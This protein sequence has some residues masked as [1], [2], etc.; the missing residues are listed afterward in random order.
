M[1]RNA[2]FRSFHRSF[3]AL[4]AAARVANAV[5]ARRYPRGEDREALGINPKAFRR[6]Q[7]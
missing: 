4:A 5:E 3:A 1:P 6:I 2:L 7:F